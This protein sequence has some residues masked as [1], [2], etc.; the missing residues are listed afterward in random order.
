MEQAMV[1]RLAEDPWTKYDTLFKEAL[2]T[3]HEGF[4]NLRGVRTDMSYRD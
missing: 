4:L 3:F 1:V 2:K